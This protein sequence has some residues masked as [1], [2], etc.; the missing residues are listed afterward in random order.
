[1]LRQE[2]VE[3]LN[4]DDVMGYDTFY[5]N[6]TPIG[7]FLFGL[8][9][10]TLIVVVVYSLN[11]ILFSFLRWIEIGMLL[12]VFGLIILLGAS[13]MFIWPQLGLHN[14]LIRR[15][16]DIEYALIE[17]RDSLR[18][19]ILL[20]SA[21]AQLED[22]LEIVNR[23]SSEVVLHEKALN[24]VQRILDSIIAKTTWSFDKFKV[25]KLLIG[26]ATPLLVSILT[27]VIA[28]LS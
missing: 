11:M 13:I 25:V 23:M 21:K 7:D 24:R 10:R 5:A 12:Y 8:T 26:S 1:M 9:W 15:K 14:L 2:K 27:D 19:E 6:T 28:S 4:I 22:D 20:K 18:S 17:K 16:K 3:D